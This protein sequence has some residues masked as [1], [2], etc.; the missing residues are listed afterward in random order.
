M[1]LLL[2]IVFICFFFQ[3][4]APNLFVYV[5]M[6]SRRFTSPSTF[7]YA[8]AKT[9][10]VFMFGNIYINFCRNLLMINCIRMVFVN[11]IKVR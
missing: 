7:N 8:A 2:F 9:P 6:A 3:L 11:H 10:L 5:R 1:I 4:L